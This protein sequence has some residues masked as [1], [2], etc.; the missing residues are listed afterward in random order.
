MSDGKPQTG[1]PEKPPI[2][3]ARHLVGSHVFRAL[4]EEGMGLVEATAAYL[5]G[6]GR[7]DSRLLTRTGSLAY[8][9]ESMRLTTRLMQLASWLLLQRAV[10]NGE[11]TAE[12]AAAE[13]AKVRL[14]GLASAAEGPGWDDLP[15]RLRDLI[16]RST[17]L[18]M[19]I[20]R[21]DG[22][23]A[24]G[25]AAPAAPDNPVLLQLNRIAEA[26]GAQ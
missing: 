11:M 1:T 8:A 4:F 23:V 25:P 13:K 7:A 19:R 6:P 15:E 10:N 14:N 2:A 5:D 21:L 9:T 26:F 3:F 17:R 18:Q 12:Q 22:A 16:D 24:G 20:R